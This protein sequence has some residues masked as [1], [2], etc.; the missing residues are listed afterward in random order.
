MTSTQA[1]TTLI[2]PGF[3]GSE[4]AHWQSWFQSKIENTHRVHQNWDEPILAHW[5][6]NIRNAIDKCNGKVWIVAHSFGCLAAILAGID[7]YQNIAG[8]MLVAP[9]DPERF[10]LGGIKEESELTGS[11]SIRSLIP[12]HR[13]P[14]PTLVIASDNDPWMQAS[15]VQLWSNIWHSEF[16]NLPSAGHINTASGFGPWHAG[17]TLFENFQLTQSKLAAKPLSPMKKRRLSGKTGQIAKLRFETR[18][19]LGIF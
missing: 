4:S 7:R 5:A 2:I 6:E 1:L 12:T 9:A 10:T 14:F 18:K 8:A 3:Q 15:K 13:L 19:Y 17:L 16:I 11:E